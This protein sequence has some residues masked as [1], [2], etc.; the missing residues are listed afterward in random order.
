VV[1]GPARRHG[2]ETGQECTNA[3]TQTV[4]EGLELE[5]ADLSSDFLQWL[6]RNLD[7]YDSAHRKL[8]DR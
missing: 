7:Q 2:R 8:A 5:R 6:R 1:S 3:E 4:G